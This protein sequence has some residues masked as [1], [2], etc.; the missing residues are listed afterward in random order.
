M[1]L[2]RVSLTSAVALLVGL[3][4]CSRGDSGD[5]LLRRAQHFADLYNWRA[6][7]P[8][9]QRAE[10]LLRKAGDMRGALY[11]HIGVLRLTSDAPIYERSDELAHLLSADHLLAGDKR[12]RLFALAVKGD[13]DGELDQS[14]ARQDWTQVTQL[15]KELGDAKWVYR[16]EGQL[17]FA[18]YYDGDLAS[19]QRRVAS[20]L[21]AATKAQDVGAEI[22]FLSTIAHGY[23]MQRLLLPMAI[24]YAKKAI[25]LADAHPDAGPPMIAQAAL[26]RALADSGK[27]TEATRLIEALLANPKLDYAERVNYLSSAGDVAI[28]QQNNR[29]AIGYFEQATRIAEDRGGSREAA[30]LQSRVSNL[31]LG[32]GDLRKAE[33]LARN[34]VNTLE[35]SGAA[36]LLPA[37]LGALADV[38]IAGKRYSDANAI[39][40]RAEALQDTLIG[41]ADSVIVKTALITGAD[42]LYSHH[43]ALLA[44]H[45]NNPEAAYDAVERGRGRAVADL[46]LS[47]R[48][49]SPDAV[50]TERRISSLQLKMASARSADDIGRLRDAIFLAEQSRAVNPDLTILSTKKFRPVPMRT[51]QHRLNPSEMLLEYV[52]AEPSSYVLVITADGQHIVRLAGRKRIDKMV[53]AYTTAVKQRLDARQQARDLYAATLAPIAGIESKSHYLIVPDGSLNLLPFDA[54]IDEHQEYVVQSHVVSYEPSSTTFYLLRSRELVSKRPKALLAVGG[55]P[56]TQT[57]NEMT[58]TERSY[59]PDRKFQ[60]LPYSEAEA[61]IAASALNSP[62]NKELEGRAATEANLKR[63][64]SR[65]YGYVHLAVHAVSSDDPDRSSLVVLSDPSSGEDGFVQASEIVQMHLPASLVVL[66]ACETDVGPVQGEEGVSALSTS[67]LL[68][69]TKTVV[70]TLWPVEDRSSLVLMKAFYEH[71]AAGQPVADSVALAKRDVLSK[72]GLNSLPIHWAGFVVQGSEPTKL[73]QAGR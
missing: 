54:M 56:Y 12:L 23:Q 64:L 65:G 34:A 5:D 40:Q 36:P 1:G 29:A 57:G 35:R 24:D 48:A 43:F 9:F 28:A 71:L 31:Y 18:D 55:I 66:S 60:D 53:A 50:E 19:C 2:N 62:D 17:G 44:E 6:A 16:A 52:V 8:L 14:A 37:K 47:H 42:Q 38:L 49:A 70:S 10:P 46:L 45:F 59:G 58:S 15:A 63:A 33:E 21:I 68:A 22:F 30:D 32:M 51:L 69:G 27:A 73:L 25:A 4:F 61:H 13:L 26:V 11:A 67:F 41:K 20:A 39:Y 72:Y 3:P 7:S